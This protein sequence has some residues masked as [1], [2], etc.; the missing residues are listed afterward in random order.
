MKIVYVGPLGAV[1]IAPPGGREIDA[2]HGDPI[3][4]PDALGENLLAQA[5][6]WQPAPVPAKKPAPAPADDEP[7]EPG[8][9][10]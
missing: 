6:N 4:V 9:E 3:E 5:D 10:V 1:I 2:R 8:R 7:A